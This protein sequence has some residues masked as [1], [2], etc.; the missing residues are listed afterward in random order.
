[1]LW[2]QFKNKNSN[3]YD[4]II[5][6]IGRRQRA[7]EQI[8]EYEIP[9]RNGNLTIHSNRFKPYL[10]PMEFALKNKDDVPLINA[11]LVGRG[12]LRTSVDKGGYFFA[13]VMSGIG[14]EKLS[15]LFDAFSVTFKVD[16]FF[17]LDEGDDTIK[18]TAP[19]TI[20]NP[21]TIYAEPYIKIIGNGNVDLIINSKVY[22]F[23]GINGYIEV[24]SELKTV[25]KDTV[26]Q[27][28]KMTGDFPVL[29]V[30]ENIISWSGNVT[31]IE[32]IPKWREL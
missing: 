13:S 27:G 18:I 20:Y 21:G 5:T 26:N 28:D 7:E 30:G 8:D 19:T 1:L 24:N 16:P 12:K 14:I 11:W 2:V 6:N 15:R 22:E 32:I 9:Y 25:Y 23:T 10:R 17:Y 3:D 4:L 31:S 29:N